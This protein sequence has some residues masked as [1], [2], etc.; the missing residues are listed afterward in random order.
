MSL[1]DQ[2]L[3]ESK[4][5]VDKPLSQKSLYD[6]YLASKTPQPKGFF[7]QL[8]SDVWDSL[9]A[10]PAPKSADAFNTISTVKNLYNDVKGAVV[11]AGEKV[12][13]AY[14]DIT[15][16]NKTKTDAAISAGSAAVG[17]VGA[18]LSP[19]G[20]VFTEGA[21]IPVLG[22]V[23][24]AVNNLFGA[25]GTAGSD[26]AAGID[27]HLPWVSQETKDKIEPLAR[28]V[29]AL[30]AQIAAGKLSGDVLSKKKTEIAAKTEQIK[31]VV[32]KEPV[33]NDAPVQA[34]LYEQYKKSET[35]VP[36][37]IQTVEHSKLNFNPD[38]LAQAKADL[39]SGVKSMTEG[40][41]KVQY[42][43]DTGMYDV[44][45]GAHRVQESIARG[46]TSI[47]AE[48][49]ITKAADDIS[50]NLVKQGF[51]A[52]P[53]EEQAKYTPQSYKAQ[54]DR[55]SSMLTTDQATIYEM[56][57]GKTPIPVDINPQ[58][59]FNAV[60]AKAMF[61]NDIKT[62]QDLSKSPIATQLSEAAQTLG[63]HGYN[64]VPNSPVRIMSDIK[65][66][67]TESFEKRTGKKESVVRNAE[68]KSIKEATPKLSKQSWS[69]FID[70]IKCNY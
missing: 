35:V 43:P 47:P 4:K 2:Y 58:I 60:E 31:E 51:E 7:G 17:T 16:P 6:Q 55:V 36:S 61:E 21:K 46:E 25:V 15:D 44:L 10:A 13:Q 42:M 45:D 59:L 56:A 39:A 65:K 20:A 48:V 66:I 49:N 23:A 33:P 53:I 69:E 18:V 57:K 19:V 41:I 63:G 29:G 12:Q 30:A 67:R 8:A 14:Q 38:D 27:Q 5:A 68:V 50:K 24:D 34:P 70:Q 1:Y 11:G 3:Q 32:S 52:L 26:V 62:L 22:Y 40:P 54:A 9:T 64:D 37:T 28:E